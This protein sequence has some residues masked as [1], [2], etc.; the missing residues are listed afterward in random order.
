MNSIIYP[1]MNED[2]AVSWKQVRDIS[3]T[4]MCVT[5]RPGNICVA[6]MMVGSA[7]NIVCSISSYSSIEKWDVEPLE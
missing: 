2:C 7:M 1:M 3:L 5:A 4:D 6:A